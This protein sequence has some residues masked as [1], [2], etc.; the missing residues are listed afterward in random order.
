MNSESFA[1]EGPP[2]GT[3]PVALVTGASSGIGEAFARNLASRGYD[4]VLVA[5]REERLRNLAGDLLRHHRCR[6][7]CL[8]IDLSAAE[9]PARVA[10]AVESAA[11]H[12]GLLVNN[13]GFGTYGEFHSRS[14]ESEVGQIE[15][16]VRALTALTRLFVP[17]MIDRHAGA[18][19]NVGSVGAFVPMPYMSVYSA[20]KAFVLSFS[21][22]LNAELSGLGVHVMCV[23]PGGT[24][25]EF[26]SASGFDETGYSRFFMTAEEVAG[27][28]LR[29]LD[30]RR[31]VSIS[32]WLNRLL[33]G[34]A[35]LTPRWVLLRVARLLFADRH[36]SSG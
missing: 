3:K 35:W 9:G 18:V 17:P 8:A 20:T 1:T 33:V 29:D 26:Q 4:L 27:Q 24:H 28:A 21:E 36:R 6:S 16:N 15:V 34:V 19:L 10:S 2:T 22:A 14:L 11:L 12:V 5:R 23:C 7:L 31:I 30:A 32:G 25:S 13:A